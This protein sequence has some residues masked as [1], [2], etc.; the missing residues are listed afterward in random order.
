ML[1]RQLVGMIFPPC[2]DFLNPDIEA[3]VQKNLEFKDHTLVSPQ[4]PLDSDFT[5]GVFY[6]SC[7]V[8]T[9]SYERGVIK[10]TEQYESAEKMLLDII[11]IYFTGE[12]RDA[13]Y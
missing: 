8:G 9:F 5:C 13:N 10:G 3:R 4:T 1:T 6:K 2:L 12:E 7:Y 11:W